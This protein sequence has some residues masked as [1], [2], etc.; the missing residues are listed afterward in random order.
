[1]EPTAQHPDRPPIP[2]GRIA[3]GVLILGMG[4]LL[5]LDRTGVLSIDAGRLIAPFVLIALGLLRSVGGWGQGWRRRDP[6]AG[7]WLIAVGAWMLIS[8][9]HVAGLTYHTSWPLIIVALG[10]L[11][12]LREIVPGRR[13]MLRGR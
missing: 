3:A 2:P 8:E 7:F 9:L 13:D 10:L 12:V 4:V 1:M 5:M 6:L 11:M